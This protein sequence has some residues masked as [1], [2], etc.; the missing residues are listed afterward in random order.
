MSYLRTLKRIRNNKTN[1]RKRTALLISKQDFITIKISNQNVQA[2]I[3]RPEIVGD[4]VSTS[5]HSRELARYGW[6]GSLNNIPACFLIGLLLGKK[7]KEKRV[8]KAVLYT[9]NNQFTSRIA[10]CLKGIIEAG[11]HIPV[12]KDS[13][14][15]ESR[16]N[17]QHIAQYAEKIKTEGI[18]KY[19]ARFSLLL[20]QGLEPEN[21]QTHIEEVATKILGRPYFPSKVGRKSEDDSSNP[22]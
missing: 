3:A 22:P 20:R 9:G 17:G 10:A 8:Q 6:K 19:N 1:Y 11:V 5:V 7:A 4:A 21:Y 18:E 2:Q 15:H 16:L 12:S 13:F 14:P